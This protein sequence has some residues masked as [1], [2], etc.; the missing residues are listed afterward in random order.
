MEEKIERQMA[1]ILNAVNSLNEGDDSHVELLARV[2]VEAK[3]AQQLL[4]EKGYGWSGL[5]LLKTVSQEVPDA[6]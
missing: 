4:R 1:V 3:E 6:N 5:S 2:I